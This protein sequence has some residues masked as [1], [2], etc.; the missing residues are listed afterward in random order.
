MRASLCVAI[1]PYLGFGLC[2]DVCRLDE[3]NPRLAEDPSQ[4]HLEV[5]YSN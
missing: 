1:T 2:C 5:I 3:L 4:T